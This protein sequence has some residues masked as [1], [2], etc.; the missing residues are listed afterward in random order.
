MVRQRG[1][2]VREMGMLRKVRQIGG[3][4][5]WCEK[6][7]EFRVALFWRKI[8]VNFCRGVRNKPTAFSGNVAAAGDLQKGAGGEVIRKGRRRVRHGQG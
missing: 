2:V 7:C 4:P 8:N 1:V 6:D 3:E 5:G